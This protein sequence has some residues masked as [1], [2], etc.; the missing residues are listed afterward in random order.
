VVDCVQRGGRE[1]RDAL[2]LRARASAAAR[3]GSS[4]ACGSGSRA[5]S[6]PTVI[7]NTAVPRP[8]NPRT[9][10]RAAPPPDA[11]SRALRR[12]S[13]GPSLE[14]SR[15]SRVFSKNL[16]QSRRCRAV[17]E[18]VTSSRPALPAAAKQ[19]AFPLAT[20]SSPFATPSA[21]RPLPKVK[22]GPRKWLSDSTGRLVVVNPERRP[23]RIRNRRA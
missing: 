2:P 14:G 20:R 21:P 1:S 6:L 19:A 17:F 7:V 3:P 4:C 23:C 18:L 13:R 12:N 8:S 15:L 22:A 9:G 5:A 11:L 10:A 16:D